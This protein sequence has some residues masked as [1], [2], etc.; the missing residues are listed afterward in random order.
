MA[1][2]TKKKQKKNKKPVDPRER[3]T[4][5]YWI[6][7]ALIT[8]IIFGGTVLFA[9]FAD[10]ND[11]REFTCQNGIY[12]RDDGR[13]YVKADSAYEALLQPVSRN[14]KGT[15]YGECEG[16][17]LYEVGY[18]DVYGNLKK[19]DA[20]NYLT[21]KSHALYIASTAILPT[22]SQ[23][24]ADTV[25]IGEFTAD[26]KTRLY[27]KSLTNQSSPEATEFVKEYLKKT[28]YAGDAT[29]LD[30]YCVQLTSAKYPYLAYML[31]LVECEDGSWYMYTKD[32]RTP[33]RMSAEW[34]DGVHISEDT[35]DTGTPSDTE[36]TPSETQ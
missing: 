6:I 30:T 17:S 32:D 18:L 34:F 35:P 22:V 31:Y 7:G 15:P 25:R 3:L 29:P 4:W 2:E 8:L 19:L 9:Y 36:K 21:D 5:K 14:K 23:L 1:N 28:L 10:L 11:V 16:L 27:R 26:E 24:E 12:T 33:I 20:D 13:I